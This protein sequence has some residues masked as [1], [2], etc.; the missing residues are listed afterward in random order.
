MIR[1]ITMHEIRIITRVNQIAGHADCPGLRAGPSAT[2]GAQQSGLT[3]FINSTLNLMPIIFLA[4]STSRLPRTPGFVRLHQSSSRLAWIWIKF[5]SQ[6]IVRGRHCLLD[7]LAKQKWY[8]LLC[9]LAFLWWR[10]RNVRCK[11]PRSS[12]QEHGWQSSL[13][14]DSH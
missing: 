8:N 9:S 1:W 10:L 7:D 3:Y 4:A 14:I 5:M 13:K 12:S 6:S 11:W 2:F